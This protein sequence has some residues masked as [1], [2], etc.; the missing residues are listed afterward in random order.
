MHRDHLRDGAESG[1]GVGSKQFVAEL[2][3]QGVDRD[4]AIATVSRRFG[5]SRRA[6]RL[7]VLSHPAWAEAEERPPRSSGRIS[8]T[9][10]S[11]YLDRFQASV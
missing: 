3:A 11:W 5:V 2:H 10:R 9:G 7:F 8:G 6:A 1:R 4:E